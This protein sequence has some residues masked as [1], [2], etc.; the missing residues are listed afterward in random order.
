MIQNISQ[1][2]I[3][4]YFCVVVE[5]GASQPSAVQHINSVRIKKLTPGKQRGADFYKEK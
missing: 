2:I 5:V 1:R 3:L 4:H